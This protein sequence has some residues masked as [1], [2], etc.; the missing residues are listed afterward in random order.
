MRDLVAAVEKRSADIIARLVK[1]GS[2]AEQIRDAVARCIE[3]SDAE[4]LDVLLKCG[5]NPNV[6]LPGLDWTL[7]HLAIEHHDVA[8]AA[9][10]LKHGANVGLTDAS[11]CTPLHHAVD[12]EADGAQQS[13]LPPKPVLTRLLLEAGAD[14]HAI[15]A[16]GKTPIDIA[17][18]YGYADGLAEMGARLR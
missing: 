2:S 11:G 5:A 18:E 6:R 17:R 15:D 9:V 1:A 3:A 12:V 7:L 8:S 4:I 13:G 16:G 10:L 14:P